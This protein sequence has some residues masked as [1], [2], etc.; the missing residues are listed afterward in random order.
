[1]AAA[2]NILLPPQVARTIKIILLISRP[3]NWALRTRLAC[4]MLKT[5]RNMA[6][7]DTKPH[8]A[9][10]RAG[11]TLVEMMVVVAI[12]SVLLALTI[13]AI[14]I[15]PERARIRATEALIAKLDGKLSAI[16]DEFNRTYATV[17]V[18]IVDR[19]LSRTSSGAYDSTRAQVI[20]RIRAMRQSFPE[21]FLLNPSFYDDGSDN[22]SDGR[23]DRD[24]PAETIVFAQWRPVDWN[25]DGVADQPAGELP[26]RALAYET[27]VEAQLENPVSHTPV[28]ARAECLYMIIMVGSTTD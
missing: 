26:P 20:A 5:G 1:M 12:V 28:T 14:I 15:L 9:D 3:D 21:Y 11:V 10:A 27:Y 19:E 7:A 13:G 16:I 4:I 18:S 24:D 8:K 6:M 2:E 22:D 23:V 17:G 25:G